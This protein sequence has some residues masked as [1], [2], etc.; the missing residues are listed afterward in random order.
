MLYVCGKPQEA[1][2]F[3]KASRVDVVGRAVH[4]GRWL[5]STKDEKT[6]VRRPDSRADNPSSSD[7][8]LL[9]CNSRNELGK[10]MF[11]FEL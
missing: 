3:S 7:K 10:Q 2:G 4:L 9:S 5:H 8:R 6:R 11:K 1:E